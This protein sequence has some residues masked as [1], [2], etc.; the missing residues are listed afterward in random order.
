MVKE[1]SSM[2]ITIRHSQNA[3]R[4]KKPHEERHL[5]GLRDKAV[6]GVFSAVA[7]NLI[8]NSQLVYLKIEGKALSRE[9]LNCLGKAMDQSTS[10]R[11]LHMNACEL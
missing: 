10:L 6:L 3:K 2:G 8:N 4:Q 7:A 9:S 1:N 11:E 5:N